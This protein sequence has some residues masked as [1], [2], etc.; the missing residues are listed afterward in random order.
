MKSRLMA[1]CAASA[2]M[3]GG[4]AAQTGGMSGMQMQQPM[5]RVQM[6]PCPTHVSVVLDPTAPAPGWMTNHAPVALSLDA[7]NPPRVESNTL[8]CYYAM[9]DGY[10][11]F[12]YYQAEGPRS[13]IVNPAKTGFECH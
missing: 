1:A 8:I 13:C 9:P 6:V 7:K 11:A 2:L 10:N 5:A 3:F 12:V 4:A